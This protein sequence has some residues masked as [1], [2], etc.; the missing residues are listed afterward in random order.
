VLTLTYQTNKVYPELSLQNLFEQIYS[1][2]LIN[3][4]MATHLIKRVKLSPGSD[5]I[6]T[7]Q[8]ASNKSSFLLKIILQNRQTLQLCTTEIIYQS[9]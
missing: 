4:N 7:Q 5:A 6:M 2:L 8:V 3:V 9:N 1:N